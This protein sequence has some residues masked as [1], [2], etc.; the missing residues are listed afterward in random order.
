M[1]TWSWSTPMNNTA[2]T[3]SASNTTATTVRVLVT[4]DSDSSVVL[5]QTANYAGGSFTDDD[6][7]TWKTMAKNAIFTNP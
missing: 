1:A 7:S 5:D 4:Q 2:Y 6:I 3:V